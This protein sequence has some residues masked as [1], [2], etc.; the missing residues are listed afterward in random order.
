MSSTE[1][2][3]PAVAESGVE[4]DPSDLSEAALHGLIEEFATR[5][6]TDYGHRDWTLEDKVDQIRRQLERG[7]ARIVFDLES[8]TASIVAAADRPGEPRS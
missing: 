2:D 7:E 5:E 3:S 8:E 1:N 4:L 6:G